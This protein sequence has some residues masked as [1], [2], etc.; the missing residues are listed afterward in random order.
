MSSNPSAEAPEALLDDAV[1]QHRAGNLDEAERLYRLALAADPDQ[2]EANHNLGTLALARGRTAEALARL[3]RALECAPGQRAYWLAYIRALLHAGHAEAART[4]IA[5][6]RRRGL[7]GAEADSLAARCEA[8]I[9]A[10]PAGSVDAMDAC[11]RLAQQDRLAEAES[12]LRRVLE[13][14]PG[15]AEAHCNL[16]SVLRQQGRPDEAEHSLRRALELEAAFPQ[17]LGNLGNVLNDL[18]RPAEAEACFRRAIAQLPDFARA[19][20]GLGMALRTQNRPVEAEAAY[21]TAL[22]LQPDF[23]EAASNLGAILQEQGRLAEAQECFRGAIAIRPDFADAHD[24]LLFTLNYDADRSAEEIFAAYRAY[25]HRFGQPQRGAWR[26]HAN[27]RDPGRRLKVGYVSPDFR[28]HAA[29]HFLEPLLAHHDK[30]QVEVHAYAELARE[31]AVTARYRGCADHW[32][33]TRGLSDEA[34]AERIRADGIDILVDLAGHT[35]GNR[36]GVFARKPAPVSASWLGYGY[37]TGLSAIDYLLT[38]EASAPAGSEPLYAE[39]PWRLATPG[40][41][42]RPAEGMGAVSPLP[43]LASGQVTFGTLTRRVRINHRTVRVWSEILKRVAGSRLLID[44]NNFREAAMVAELRERFAEQG[45]GGER[46]EI[47][48]HSPP[49]DILRQTDIGLDC[50]PHNSGTTL[51][52]SLYLGVP[53][54][55]LAGRP[56]V[57]RLG[58]AILQGLG[59][60]EWIAHSEEDYVGKAVALAGDLDALARRRAGLRDEMQASPLMD[61]AGFARKVEAAYREM[62]M[63]WIGEGR[64]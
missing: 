28:R 20:Y 58:S 46:L 4:L 34:L 26:A 31:D 13:A 40:Y 38:D 63:R 25:D 19:H 60:A 16:G 57:G 43:A 2:P 64:P 55:T 9:A 12:L 30:G 42:F 8:R 21:R 11:R 51:F 27:P 22:A 49:W 62:W 1:R 10:P 50:F 29:V 37:T 56:T 33:A 48:Y 32:V 41:A 44:S 5:E 52:E 47:G 61:E 15:L 54:I 18:R 45:I 17:A 14:R 7:G 6:G 53:F 3:K 24:G 35:S 36:L 59:R 23:V 39:V